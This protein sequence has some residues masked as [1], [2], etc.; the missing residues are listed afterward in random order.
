MAVIAPTITTLET[1]Y[2]H[3][4]QVSWGPFAAGDTFT[5]Y[6]NPGSADRS[7]HVFGT[8]GASTIT[9]VGSNETATPTSM[10][11]LHDP[12]G[13]A[14]SITAAGITQISEVTNWIAPVCTGGAASGMTA[15][16][17]IRRPL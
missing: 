13:T 17:V 1:L 3:A 12:S 9:V 6:P 7:I 2:G 8:F 14:I 5:P 11:A 10:V 16:L 4:H 15:A